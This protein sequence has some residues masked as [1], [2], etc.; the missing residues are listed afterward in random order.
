MQNKVTT[1]ADAISVIRDGDTVLVSGFVGIGTPDELIVALEKR[2]LETGHPC[3][4]T[5]VFAAAPGDAGDRGLNR[6]AYPG[7]IKRAIGGHWSLVP[8]LAKLAVDNQIEAYNLPLGCISQMYRVIAGGKPGLRTKVGLRTFVDPRLDGGRMNARTTEPLVVLD[9]IDGEEW[10]FYKAFKIDVAFLRGTTADRFGNTTMEREVLKLDVCSS[11]MAAHNSHGIVFVQVERVAERGSLS[12]KRVMIPGNL[13]GCVVISKPENHCQTYATPYKMEF[14]GELRV[15]LEQF[16][17]M[18]LTARKIIARRVALELPI[19]G[20]VNLGIGVPEGV[21]AVAAEE[22]ML[23]SVSLTAEAGTIGGVPQSGLDFGAALNPDAVIATNTQFDF[24]DGGGIDMACLGM[25]Q[26]D[27]KGNVNVSKFGSRFAGAGGFINISQNA[28]RVAFAGSFTA[29]DLDIAIEDGKVRIIKEGKNRKFVEN[30]EHIT[31]SGELAAETKQPVL[32]ITERCVFSITVKG[33]ELIEV[34]PGIDIDRDILA[35]MGFKPIMEN[36]RLMDA[37]IFSP[38]SMN[39]KA[40]LLDAPISR[41]IQLDEQTYTLRLNMRGYK[42]KEVKDLDL[43][44]MRIEELCEPLGQKVDMI[45]WYDG[46]Y[47]NTRLL[48]AYN[49]TIAALEKKYYKTSRRYTRDPFI[50]LKLASELEKRGISTQV[51]KDSVCSNMVLEGSSNDWSRQEDQILTT[52][53]AVGDVN[54]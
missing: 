11:A 5:L 7:L 21:A 14:A 51:R 39:L 22:E 45:A 6:L 31:F 35:H 8:K 49:D 43:I 44:R 48:D 20:V 26:V 42:I 15:P 28:A 47:L 4:L 29:G 2:F 13:V 38:E 18:P 25:A 46:F 12:P 50:R 24:Y 27:A 52:L 19:G 36:V 3:D 10:L 32:Y 23:D 53:T 54:T 17:A 34:A 41:R 9:E 33:V 1:A 30:V 40:S 37:K 16:E